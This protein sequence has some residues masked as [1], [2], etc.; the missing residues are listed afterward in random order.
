MEFSPG[1]DHNKG[2]GAMRLKLVIIA[3]LLAAITGAGSCIAIVLAIFFSLKPFSHP[4]LLV[5]AT[6]LMPLTA[7][8]LSS[9]F[10]YRHTARRRRLQAFLTAVLATLLTLGL[11]LL[12]SIVS[13]RRRPVE[14]V[15]PPGPHIAT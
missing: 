5:A 4:G 11:L 3:S 13:A 8:A 6:F 12:A 10:V 15:Q 1:K 2:K 9:I 14:P 7:I